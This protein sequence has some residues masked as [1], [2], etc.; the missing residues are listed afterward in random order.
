M[1]LSA[2]IYRLKRQARLAAR[3]E[4]IP[5]H[6]ALDPKAVEEGFL[7]WSHLASSSTTKGPVA[8]IL[9]QLVPGDLILVGARPGHGKT[10]LGLELASRATELGRKGFFFTLDYH[11]RDVED[12]FSALGIGPESERVAMIVYTSDE[13]SAD[14][15]ISRLEHFG[16]PVVV[17]IGYLQPLDQKRTNPSL[18]DQI[19]TQI[20]EG[21]RRNLCHDLAI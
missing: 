11:E 16:E 7:S 15:V 14:Y 5:L 3:K 18:D 17:V 20:R 9:S 6:E 19:S 12:R 13:V 21:H 10:L 4:R 1:H 8:T 2:S